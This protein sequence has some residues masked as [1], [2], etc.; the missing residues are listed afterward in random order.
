M[1]WIPSDHPALLFRS[2][3]APAEH[4]QLFYSVTL[5]QSHPAQPWKDFPVCP[6]TWITLPPALQP[7]DISRIWAAPAVQTEA[8]LTFARVEGLHT[9]HVQ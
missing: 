8:R 7:V 4:L 2:F 5:V 6:S 3:H 9:R 1:L